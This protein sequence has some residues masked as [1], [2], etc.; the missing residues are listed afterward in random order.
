MKKTLSII[1]AALILTVSQQA[2][3]QKIPT[4]Y[5]RGWGTELN[6]NPFDG[7]LSLNNS[8]GQLK[9][10][11]FMS[12]DIALRAGISIAYKNDNEQQKLVYGTLPYD[13]TDKKT[14]ILTELSLGAEKHFNGERRL[15]PYIGF[16]VGIGI[17]SSKQEYEYNSSKMTVKGAWEVQSLY[18]NGSYYLTQLSYD[19]RGF[20]STNGSLLTGFD[21]YMDDNFYF[22]YELGFGYEFIKYS[23]I[24][25]TKDQN[26]PST[27][28]SPELNTKSWRIGP[29]LMNGVRIG[30]NF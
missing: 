15:S 7:S 14:S 9:V 29:R 21:Y 6:F 30:Y 19:E 10:R 22:G 12:N 20:L 3:S 2:K 8:T 1:I 13:A 23:K 24:E 5:T 25:I 18:Y 11:K 16:E 26:F 28:T 27:S 17:K 4:H